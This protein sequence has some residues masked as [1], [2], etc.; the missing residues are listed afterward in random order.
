MGLLHH[1]DHGH[2][3]THGSVDSHII[4]NKEATRVLLLSLIGLMMT[5]VFQAVVAAFTGST[6]LL[7]DTIHNFGDSLTSIP[8]WIAFM[9]S[10][11]P[12][13]K[14]FTYGYSRSEDLAGLIIVLVILFSAVIAGYESVRR[15]IVGSEMTHLGVTAIAAVIGFIGNE[16][17]AVYRIRMGKKMGSAALVADGHHARI[18]GWTSLAVLV[19]VLGAWVGFPVLDPI[20]GLVITVMI[21]FIVKD[22]AKTIFTRLL[23]GIDPEVVDQMKH[24]AAQIEGVYHVSDVKARWLGHHITAEMSVTLNSHLTVKEGH[25][26]VKAVIHR[27]HHEV[28]HVT[29]VQ[30]HTDPMEEQGSVYHEPHTEEHEH[31]LESHHHHMHAHLHGAH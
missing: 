16:A 3:H 14:R 5:A 8:L 6:A 18:D 4:E 25:D 29:A 22:S 28:D 31:Q 26:V 13:T 24:V 21:L 17:V 1:H 11:R 20:I 9:L 19:G 23:D 30:V 2:T 10:R 12:P 27:L 7:A 15:L